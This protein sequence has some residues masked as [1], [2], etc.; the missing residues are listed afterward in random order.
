MECLVAQ[1]VADLCLLCAVDPSEDRTVWQ[2]VCGCFACDMTFRQVLISGRLNPG[3]TPSFFTLLPNVILSTIRLVRL[4]SALYIPVISV[5]ACDISLQSPCP[6][7]SSFESI[8]A[9]SLNG[10]CPLFEHT[11]L[12]CH[13]SLLRDIYTG[14]F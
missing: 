1:P 9:M 3:A 13:A 2:F 11:Q 10:W 7:Y 5:H 8:V 4:A 12:L 14:L 6:C